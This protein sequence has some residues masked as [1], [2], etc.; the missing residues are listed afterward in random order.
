M[1][2]PGDLPA[3][4]GNADVLKGFSAVPFLGL[5]PQA[6]PEKLRGS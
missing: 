3:A 2:K 4:A 5:K 6:K 1:A